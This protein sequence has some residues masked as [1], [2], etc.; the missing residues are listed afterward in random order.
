[1]DGERVAA[2]AEAL[3]GA[4]D[5]AGIKGRLF[6]EDCD[7]LAVVVADFLTRDGTG[8]GMVAVP[9]DVLVLAELDRLIVHTEAEAGRSFRDGEYGEAAVWGFAARHVDVHA[10]PVRQ[11]AGVLPAPVSDVVADGLD[12]VV[13]AMRSAHFGTDDPVTV[14]GVFTAAEAVRQQAGRVRYAGR[15]RAVRDAAASERGREGGTGE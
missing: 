13:T 6:R 14:Q 7:F 4:V 10:F 5:D 2:L 12:R 15:M 9:A 11:R 3:W 8:D 1:M